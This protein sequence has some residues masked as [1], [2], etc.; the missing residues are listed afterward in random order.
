MS[1]SDEYDSDYTPQS[2][3]YGYE[4]RDFDN[5][6][7]DIESD[8][9]SISESGLNYSSDRED[10]EP[11]TTCADQNQQYLPDLSQFFTEETKQQFH[12]LICSKNHKNK[13]RPSANKYELLVRYATDPSAPAKLQAESNAKSEAKRF[14]IMRGMNLKRRAKPG[15]AERYVVPW[16]EVWHIIA[17]SQQ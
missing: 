3:L 17:S 14:F 9:S 6:E 2:P 5:S 15:G 13:A 1:S 8:T 10:D 11:D 7:S 4:F 16:W 12:R